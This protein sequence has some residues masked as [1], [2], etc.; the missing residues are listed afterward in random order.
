MVTIAMFSTAIEVENDGKCLKEEHF[1]PT[2]SNWKFQK[3]NKPE[4]IIKK[5]RLSYW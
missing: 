1:R 5:L 4:K 2:H 3:G